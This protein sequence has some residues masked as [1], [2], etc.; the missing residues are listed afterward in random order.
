MTSPNYNCNEAVHEG[1][2]LRKVKLLELMH[3]NPQVEVSGF[4]CFFHNLFFL[5]NELVVSFP[6]HS[7][8]FPYDL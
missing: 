5:W 8:H 2:A 1:Y 6:K 7:P 4:K 3:G